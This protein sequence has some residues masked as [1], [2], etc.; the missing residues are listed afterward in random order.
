MN[1]ATNY[2]GLKLS[3]PLVVSASPLPRSLDNLRQMEASGASAVVLWS[4]FE[5]QIEHEARELDYY[6]HYGTERFAESLTYFPQVETFHLAGDQYVEHVTKARQA[7]NIPIIAS[8]NGVSAGGWIHYARRLQD[9]GADALELN[10]YF[11]PTDP[12]VD[13]RRVEQAHLD[14]LHAVRSAVTI[15]VAVKLSPFFSAIANMAQ[16]LSQAGADGLVL[17]NRFYA[18][19]IDVENLQV[20]RQLRLSD[21]GDSLLP[22][23]WI[24]ILRDR[25][26][27]SLAASGGIHTPQ[28]MAA[29]IMAGADVTMVCSALLQRGIGHLRTLRDG[30]DAIGRRHG[31]ADVGEMRGILSH[32]SSAEPGAFERANYMKTLN[33]YGRTATLE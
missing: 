17:F 22:M 6:L 12:T 7:V 5:E 32:R 13:G 10:V 14:V 9:A 2:M 11:L 8:L 29:L 24:A 21:S 18:P 28:D 23:R 30:L 26:E 33:E 27:V 1:L 20:A 19:T 15:P 3:S 4:L 16:S 25:V 31:Y